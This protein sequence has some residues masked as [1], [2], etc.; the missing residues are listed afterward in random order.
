MQIYDIL[1]FENKKGEKEM[2]ELG[3]HKKI[4]N[5]GRVVIP[6][7]YMQTLGI[8]NN[9]FID[10]QLY[11]NELILKRHDS[12]IDYESLLRKCLV[13]NYGSEY[14]DYFISEDMEKRFI[15]TIQEFINQNVKRIENDDNLLDETF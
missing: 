7:K 14:Q 11:K 4:D 5:L 15:D 9:S 6:K 12:S 3:I 1:I 10:I 13:A 8:K 2:K